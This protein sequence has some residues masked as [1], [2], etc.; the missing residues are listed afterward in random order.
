MSRYSNAEIPRIMRG[1]VGDL[2]DSFMQP[3]DIQGALEPLSVACVGLRD[4]DDPRCLLASGLTLASGFPEVGR[5]PVDCGAKSDNDAHSITE[6]GVLSCIAKQGNGGREVL[7]FFPDAHQ[8]VNLTRGD[9]GYPGS[10]GLWEIDRVLPKSVPIASASISHS[11][12]KDHDR[13]F[14]GL[15][16]RL[17]LSGVTAHHRIADKRHDSEEAL[18]RLSYRTLL[19]R[20]S[21][22]RGSE[23]EATR[24]RTEKVQDG[25]RFAVDMLDAN[26]KDISSLVRALYR[27]KSVYD[28]RV[29]GDGKSHFVHHVMP[30]NPRV[31]FAASEYMP[32]PCN[33]RNCRLGSPAT[34]DFLASVN[35]LPGKSRSWLVVTY[36]SARCNRKRYDSVVAN[37]VKDFCATN[38]DVMGRHREAMIT[39]TNLYCS[40]EDYCRLDDNARSFVEE[41]IARAV[42]IDP[43]R[44]YLDIMAT[45]PRGA[46]LINKW[47]GK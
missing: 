43:F 3:R 2:G 12:C 1:L 13:D 19:F 40:P 16:D 4:E 32:I 17:N 8:L 22:L 14:F 7:R 9:A 27:D 36:P 34:D 30:F 38:D 10:Q 39:W 20:L 26:L 44:L 25:N 45:H 31:R 15:V 11:T 21:Q 47:R 24:K 41:S 18:F 35:V 42:C 29:V 28:K 6:N 46:D 33:C 23:L 5:R 37:W